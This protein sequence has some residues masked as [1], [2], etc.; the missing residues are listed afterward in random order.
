MDKTVYI[1]LIVSFI[2]TGVVMPLLIP[3]LHRLKFG[4]TI[5]E[6]GPKWHEKKNGTPTMGGVCFLL[7]SAIISFAVCSSPALKLAIGAAFLFGVIG[8][9][10]DFI[11]I[12]F[13]R[14]LGLTEIQKL[15][16][17]TLVSV[18]FLVLAVKLGYISTEITIP[19]TKISLELSWFYVIFM[20]V[21]LIGFTNAV[22]LTDGLDGLAASVTAVVTL[23]FTVCAIL[24]KNY[25]VSY[26]AAAVT[27]SLL[28][29]LIYNYHP[30]KVF[31]GDTGSLYLGGVVSVLAILLKLELILII[32][33]IIYVIEAFSVIIQVAY[34]K[35]TKK[36]IFLMAPIHHH[37]EMKGLKEVQIVY[38]FC[39]V[40]LV[41]SAISIFAVI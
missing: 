27:G 13:K 38:I 23:F 10:D 14:N 5:R 16:F 20:T 35:K 3:V 29:F 21:F 1:A 11:K 36:R 33:G 9:A 7:I 28:G 41:C 6:I 12:Y 15:I 25:D 26:F 2:L 19:F 8:F 32:V 22:N 34:F 30:A 40:T 39:L 31:M 37:F 17:Q 24:V 4:Q 18:V